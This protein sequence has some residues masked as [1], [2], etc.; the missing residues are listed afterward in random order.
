[1][2]TAVFIVSAAIFLLAADSSTVQPNNLTVHEWGTFTSVAGEDGSSVEWD[3]LGC[4]DDLPGFVNAAGYRGFKFRLQGTV[5]METP[6]MYFYSPREMAASVQV[7]FPFG[8]ITE[9]YPK[10]D[11]EIYESKSLMDSMRIN[12]SVFP[13]KSLMDP[14]PAGLDASLVR[15]SSSLNGIDTS[16]RHLMGSIGWNDVQI[17]P[18]STPEFPLE[19]APSRYYAARGTDSAPVTVGDQHEKFLFYRGVGRFQ[20]PLTARMAGDGK[21]IVGNRGTDQIPAAILFENRGG[22]LGFR[23]AGAISDAV[24]LDP[25]TLDG[26][27]SNLLSTLELTLEAQGLFPRE[28]LAMVE[29]WRDSWFEEGSRLI[30]I[31]P[32]RAID[33]VL[34][35]HVEP[36]A[37]NTARVFVGRI[38]LVTPATERAVEQ[39]MAKGDWPA[40]DRY[41]RFLDPILRRI[42]GEGAAQANQVKLFRRN[43]QN[44]PS[45]CW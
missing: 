12:G 29:T 37:A 38:E 13:T 6:V 32:S 20:V 2:K 15:L 26:S 36:A 19:G 41:T 28:A 39:A 22:H 23:N 31:V 17:Q 25:P 43:M 14:P 33:A 35:L 8:V 42:S 7:R 34:P 16:L 40:L 18:G 10:G 11:N 24:T 30:Y 1:M 45:Q 5:R 44:R 21:V 9:W 4:K 27:L 3:T